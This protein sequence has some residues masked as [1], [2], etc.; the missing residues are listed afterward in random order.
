MLP[1]ATEAKD[2]DI[3][4]RLV[5]DGDDNVSVSY[6]GS[7]NWGKYLRGEGSVEGCVDEG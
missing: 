7:G 6:S 2:G 3:A 1:E 4:P 5:T